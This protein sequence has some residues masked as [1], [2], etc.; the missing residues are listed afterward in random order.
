[1]KRAVRR[2]LGRALPPVLALVLAAC[3]PG[4]GVADGPAT[5]VPVAPAAPVAP[6][7]PTVPAP[8]GTAADGLPAARVVLVRADG[9]EAVVAV[10]V[11][12]APDAR[13]RGLMG[14]TDLPAGTGMLF[15]FPELAAHGGFWMRGTP[16]PLDISFVADG[17]VVA[18]ATMTPCRAEPCPIT[19]PGRPYD[20]AL[21]VPAGWLASERIGPGTAVRVDPSEHSSEQSPEQS[22]E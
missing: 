9:T 14:V 21:E 16:I 6:A 2:S 1:V 22:S 20:A 18:V 3:A 8:L 15:M 10:R 5:T 13:A 17:E 19:H 7:P 12:A 11:A 4:P